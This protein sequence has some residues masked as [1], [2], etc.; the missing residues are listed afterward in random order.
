MI[1]SIVNHKGGVG[2]TTTAINLGVALA[3]LGQRVLVIDSDTQC[4]ATA[5]LYGG[6]R[7]SG[8]SFCEIIDPGSAVDIAAD[9]IYCTRHQGLHIIPNV[10]ESAILGPAI[11]LSGE[12]ALFLM[13]ERLR[14]FARANYDTTLIDCPPS[15]ETIVISALIASDGA[16]IPTSAGSRYSFEG[17]AR[18][19]EF[20]EDIRSRYNPVLGIIKILITMVDTRTAIC[21][22]VMSAIRRVFAE[23]VLA[24]VIPTNTDVQRAETMGQSIFGYRPE[25]PAAL[26]YLE[27]ARELIETCLGAQRH[28]G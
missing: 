23:S 20:A 2:K 12:K 19:W 7:P 6:G 21:R 4:N 25:A 15:L 10:P 13:R 28:D 5:V 24:H 1:I 27:V 8:R 14:K 17:L 11:V 16:I 9:C 3:N 22:T 26:A 18:A